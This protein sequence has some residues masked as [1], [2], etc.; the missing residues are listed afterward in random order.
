[1]SPS[2]LL[3]LTAASL[4]L[5]AV[6]YLLPRKSQSLG[7]LVTQY[8]AQRPGKK[9]DAT[10]G[11][12]DQ[13]SD[14]L[15]ERRGIA[16]RTKGFILSLC[17]SAVTIG[18]LFLA[19][20]SS[21]I[22][23]LGVVI[24]LAG[25]AVVYLDATSR[26]SER[27]KQ[28]AEELPQFLLTVSSAMGAGLTLDQALRELS[29]DKANVVQEE[30]FKITKVMSFGDSI[31]NELEALE[32]KLENE[33][34][35]TLRQAA[36]IGRESGSSLIPILETVAESTLQRARVRREIASLTAEGMMSAYVIIALPFVIF[37]FLL[38]TQP[39]YVDV[40]WT[41]P[42]G[43]VL[44]LGALGLISVGWIWLKRMINKE[45]GAV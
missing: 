7:R 10:E 22:Q 31:D 23:L 42:T 26:A 13:L 30:F 4:A 16:P 28:F 1:M 11:V 38:F 18:L 33:E 2:V 35:K 9:V 41:T 32:Q 12:M 25:P 5:S 8:S 40:F 24:L 34:L 36:A 43:G 37:F 17:G 27:K 20:G 45:T 14:Y 19:L 21:Q 39:S 44:A 15:Y 6:F 29:A 3:I